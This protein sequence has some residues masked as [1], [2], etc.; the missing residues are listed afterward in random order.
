[1]NA[2]DL[3]AGAGGTST[4]ATWAGARILA[5]VNHWPRAV[6][7]HTAAHP[8]AQH[9]LED[10]AV[11]DPTTLPAHDLLLA[12]PSCTG[13]TRARGKE[14]PHHD[15]ARATAWCVIRVAE[16]QRPRL[17]CVENVPELLSWKLYRA[18]RMALTDLG[19]RV[20][21]Q[22][23]DA[24]DAG[25]PQHRRRLFVVASRTRRPIVVPQP[26]AAH[27]PARACIDLDTGPWTP[28]AQWCERTRAR[29][30]QGAPR[31]ARRGLARRSST[32]SRAPRCRAT[33]DGALVP[34]PAREAAVNDRALTRTL[35]VALDALA[36]ALMDLV[37]QLARLQRGVWQEDHQRA[38]CGD[39]CYE[40]RGAHGHHLGARCASAVTATPHAARSHA[41]PVSQPAKVRP[42]ADTA[43]TI[44]RA[45][46]MIAVTTRPRGR[47]RRR[48][49]STPARRG[50]QTSAMRR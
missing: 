38:P 6:E 29:I 46:P 47:A 21:E 17:V 34:R 40:S 13:H 10:A 22:V 41:P 37:A 27:V 3:F 43:P 32:T 28:V 25:V 44:T 39:G 49:A 23:I 30:T 42:T 7:T 48:A 19:Y 15:A 8:E 20:S 4:G 50:R 24:A 35:G 12:S 1:M 9:H 16:A 11:L 18:W 33:V 26:T 5:A 45:S 14:Q 2:V 36:A 31:G